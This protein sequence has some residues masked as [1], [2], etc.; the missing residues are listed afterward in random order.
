MSQRSKQAAAVIALAAAACA[1]TV[2]AQT[3]S[4]ALSGRATLGLRSVDVDGSTDKYREDI[5]L[6]DGVRLFDFSFSYA[7]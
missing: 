5:N 2:S 4:S 6:D 7:P 1:G 3:G